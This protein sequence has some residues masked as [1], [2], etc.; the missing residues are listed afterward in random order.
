M[1]E[2]RSMHTIQIKIETSPGG[3]EI[4]AHA[5]DLCWISGLGESHML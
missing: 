4:P 2:I 5:G 3:S 1:L